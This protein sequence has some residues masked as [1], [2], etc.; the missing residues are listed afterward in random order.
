MKMGGCLRHG[1]VSVTNMF[2]QT[3][4]MWETLQI[5]RLTYNFKWS[6]DFYY[7]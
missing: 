7:V 2:V 6:H 1:E 5:C 4:F 3:C